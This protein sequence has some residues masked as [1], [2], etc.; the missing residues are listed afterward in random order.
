MRIT[1][2]P[3]DCTRRGPPTGR[4]ATDDDPTC[5]GGA[6]RAEA[7]ERWSSPWWSP[8]WSSPRWPEVGSRSAR[9]ERPGG[10]RGRAR[11]AT[12]TAIPTIRIRFIAGWIAGDRFRTPRHHR[13]RGADAPAE[14]GLGHTGRRRSGHGRS[15]APRET[16]CR[17]VFRPSSAAGSRQPSPDGSARRSRAARRPRPQLVERAP[18]M[19]AVASAGPVPVSW[20]SDVNGIPLTRAPR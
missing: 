8:R 13:A 7:A 11:V 2:R 15:A 12:T 20:R 17:H 18:T 4:P 5:A 9:P 3:R 19:V 1:R 6:A 14:H 10:T 16:A